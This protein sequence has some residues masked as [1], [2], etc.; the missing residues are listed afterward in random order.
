MIVDIAVVEFHLDKEL[1][2]IPRK[3]RKRNRI[4]TAPSRLLD[5]PPKPDIPFLHRDFG[6]AEADEF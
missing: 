3:L 4:D 1:N 5:M 2:S 6:L